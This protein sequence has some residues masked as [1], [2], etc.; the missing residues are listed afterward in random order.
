MRQLT[1]TNSPWLMFLLALGAGVSVASTYYAQPI[2]PLFSHDLGLSSNSVGF[3]P[4]LTQLGYALGIFLLLPLGDKYSRRTLI[5]LKGFILASALLLLSLSQQ[6]N[7][8]LVASLVIGICATIAQDIV[9]IA[10]II[11]P[12]GQ[13]GRY[14]GSVMTGLLLGIL[15][16]RTVSGVLSDLLSWRAMYQIAALVVLLCVLALWRILPTS[17]Y[18]ADI[19][20]YALLHSMKNLWQRYPSLRSALYAQGLLSVAFSAFWSSLALF[21]ADDFKLGSSAAGAF[22][23]A[24]AM[25]AFA[26]PVAGRLSDKC[27]AHRVTTLGALLVLIFFA[28]MYLLPALSVTQQLIVIAIAAAGFDFGVQGS[29]VAHQSLIYP[30]NA[31]ARARLNA[32]LFTGI[33]LGMALGSWLGNWIYLRFSWQGLVSLAVLCALAALLIRL[34]SSTKQPLAQA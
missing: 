3:I 31:D 29:L 15:L 33:F 21:L 22:G 26:A 5:L 18:R 4:T 13:Q 20:Y 8:L 6:L 12:K 25:G 14:V 17:P 1:S 24:G 19:S 2:L 30:L 32:I 27:G 7:M 34:Y 16:S 28:L 10:A 11:A 23:I 9:P